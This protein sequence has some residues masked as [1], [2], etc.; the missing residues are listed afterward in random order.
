[1][2]KLKLNASCEIFHNLSLIED[3]SQLESIDLGDHGQKY[4]E[5]FADNVHEV[6]PRYQVYAAA[7]IFGVP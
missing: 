3:L 7:V 6:K 5:S 2:K 4:Y 1:M